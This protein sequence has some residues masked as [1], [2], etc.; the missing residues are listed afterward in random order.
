M[1]YSKEKLKINGDLRIPLFQII[2]NSKCIKHVFAYLEFTVDFIYRC[3]VSLNSLMG[4]PDSVKISAS[5]TELCYIYFCNS[6]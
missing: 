5:W 1:A 6:R 4:I 3:L 2:L